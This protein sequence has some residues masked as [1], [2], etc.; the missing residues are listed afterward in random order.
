MNSLILPV[1]MFRFMISVWRVV[2]DYI[3]Q[4]W[5][6]EGSCQPS[7]RRVSSHVF[8]PLARS[9]QSLTLLPLA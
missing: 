6:G 1:T 3:I 5:V 9:L 2:W 8:L 7:K 4:A